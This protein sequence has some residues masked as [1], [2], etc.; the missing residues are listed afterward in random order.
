MGLPESVYA[1]LDRRL[2][3]SDAARAARYPGE[4]AGR[5]PVHTVYVPADAVTGGLAVDWGARALAAVDGVDL[6]AVV[7]LDP[8]VWPRVLA[9]LAAEP[10]EDLRVDAEDGYRGTDEDADVVAAAQA[11]GAGAPAFFGIRAKSLEPATRRRGVRSLDLF[12]GVLAGH[13]GEVLVTLPKV[14]DTDQVTAMVEL[15]GALEYAHGV[16]LGL[17]LQ[18][19]TPQAVL[20]ADGRATAAAMVHAAGGRCRGLH[21]GTYDYSASLGVAAAHQACDHPVADHAKAVM[22]VAVAGTGARAVDGS[23]NVLPVGDR[24]AV[25]AAWRRHAGLVTRALRTG[26]YQGWD[27]AGMLVRA[28]D[29]GAADEPEVL[30][31]LGVDRTGLNRL[32]GRM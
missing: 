32:A 8:A 4:P 15:L 30:G 6:P 7:G 26:L 17:E 18:V 23:S 9:K 24:A 28:L 31:P 29:C 13:P 10:V 2:A 19:E 16:R 21:Y 20:G 27:L 22:Q 5:Q 11:L 3:A 1:D 14:T 25:R 12:L